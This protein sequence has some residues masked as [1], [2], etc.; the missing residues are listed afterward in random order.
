MLVYVYFVCIL[1]GL[2]LCACVCFCGR[3]RTDSSSDTDR[4]SIW[5]NLDWT[6]SA[7]VDRPGL[8]VGLTHV[9]GINL[10]SV[11]SVVIMYTKFSSR[12]I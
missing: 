10:L 2:A 8:T 11:H 1:L 6:R 5:V 4:R 7:D 12:C 9:N 3:V